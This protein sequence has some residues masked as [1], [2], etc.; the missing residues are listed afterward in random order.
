MS[1]P[2]MLKLMDDSKDK[3]NFFNID[4]KTK[5]KNLFKM[6]EMIINED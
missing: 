3:L 6:A 5:N 2:N 4:S 1:S